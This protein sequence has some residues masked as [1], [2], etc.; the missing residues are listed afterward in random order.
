[1]VWVNVLLFGRF[2]IILRVMRRVNIQSIRNKQVGAVWSWQSTY[3]V[4][5]DWGVTVSFSNKKEAKRFLTWINERLTVLLIECNELA[6]VL[7]IEFRRG[8]LNLDQDKRKEII[9]VFARCEVLF[10]RVADNSGRHAIS[11]SVVKDINDL[12]GA[13]GEVAGVLLE[14][15]KN[16]NRF[17]DARICN[18]YVN[19]CN[20]VMNVLAGLP[21]SYKDMR[22]IE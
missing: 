8:F 14:H 21:T 13:L 22:A 19:R 20:E 10:A 2:C 17:T 15:N 9:K 1:V 3:G 6:G 4:W 11:F 12:A 16:K 18:G 5:L 7:Y